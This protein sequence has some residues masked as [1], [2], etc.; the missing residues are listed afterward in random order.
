MEKMLA[1]LFDEESKAY[2]ASRALK[3]LDGDGSIV[4]YA[5]R[6]IEKD[7]D[8]TIALKQVD[9]E[10]PIH[11]VSGTAIG[12]VIGLLVRGPLGMV[13]G[14]V[15]GSMTGGLAGSIHDFY[16]AEVSAEFLDEV[17]TALKPGKFA[18]I[19][20]V[21]EDWITPVDTEMEALGASVMRTAKQSFEAEQRAKEVARLR[22]EIEQ[23]KAELSRADAD[24]QA[25]LHAG[26]DKL[27]AQV[28][29]RLTQAQ[30]RLEQMKSEA[31]AKV[32]ALHAAREKAR[33]DVQASHDAEEKRIRQEYE[34]SDARL[35]ALFS[36]QCKGAS[37][38][39]EKEQHPSLAQK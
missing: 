3:Q 19:A 12:A 4:V 14:A 10:F 35:R 20:D 23:T 9:F 6:V 7:P 1:I 37:A 21:D 27:N 8:G 17:S 33:A 34:E 22:A 24:R 18:V 11:S 26:I 28:E 15:V 39:Q 30:Q 5:E 29:A 13:G 16:R 32:R 31:E 38:R 36:E 2:Q 25:K